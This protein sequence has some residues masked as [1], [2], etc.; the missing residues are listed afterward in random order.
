M[1]QRPRI[2]TTTPLLVVSDLQRSIDFYCQKLAFGAPSVHGDPPCF[3]MVHR[4]QF[5]LMLKKAEKPEH[6]HP[7]GPNQVWDIYIRI[8]DVPAEAAAL[9]SLGVPL[10]RG[11]ATAFYDMLEFEVLDPDGYR[12]CFGQDVSP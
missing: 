11:P 5:E 7:N 2:L 6:V 12:I 4:H 9:Q 3:A 8:D 10:A 1:S